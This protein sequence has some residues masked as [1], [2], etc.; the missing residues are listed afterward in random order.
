MG[1]PL[2]FFNETVKLTLRITGETKSLTVLATE[3][4]IA[5]RLQ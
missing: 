2:S 4:H 5:T 1:V 3:V